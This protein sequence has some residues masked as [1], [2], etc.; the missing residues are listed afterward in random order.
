[1]LAIGCCIGHLQA[2][3][4]V[5]V[6]GLGARKQILKELNQPPFKHFPLP[7]GWGDPYVDYIGGVLFMV[8]KLNRPFL[9][10][11]TM[12]SSDKDPHIVRPAAL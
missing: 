5:N 10:Y 3:L 1:M 9:S 4:E 11:L 12:N 7:E 6:R 2:L 8:R